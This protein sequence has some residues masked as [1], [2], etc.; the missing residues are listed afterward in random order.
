[1]NRLL[2]AVRNILDGENKRRFVL[3]PC[4]SQELNVSPQCCVDVSSSIRLFTSSRRSAAASNKKPNPA[5][6]AEPWRSQS[7][8]LVVE[9][10]WSTLWGYWLDG[11]ESLCACVSQNKKLLGGWRTN[12]HF[13]A[14][15][16]LLFNYKRR[17]LCV[18][19]GLFRKQRNTWDENV[20]SQNL[21]GNFP[22]FWSF[23]GFTK[24]IFHLNWK[25][26]TFIFCWNHF[27]FFIRFFCNESAEDKNISLTG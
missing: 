18:Y 4:E 7:M 10:A 22:V 2:T 19:R 8:V 21:K 23:F 5:S 9:G 27:L 15:A 11:A 1:M 6:D 16:F 20:I 3:S 26:W 24:I 17:E 13:S 14:A 12:V 25:T